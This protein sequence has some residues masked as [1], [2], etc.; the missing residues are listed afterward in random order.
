MEDFSNSAGNVGY[1]QLDLSI[2]SSM[3]VV[4]PIPMLATD[5]DV[6]EE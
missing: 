3:Q 1:L 5:T 4:E 2:V 6:I